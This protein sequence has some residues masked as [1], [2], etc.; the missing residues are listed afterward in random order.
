MRRTGCIDGEGGLHRRYGWIPASAGMTERGEPA[1][2]ER[3][4]FAA[5]EREAGRGHVWHAPE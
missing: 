1:A 4:R 2:T 3:G 5:T